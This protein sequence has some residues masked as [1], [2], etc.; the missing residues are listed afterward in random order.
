[1]RIKVGID[2]CPAMDHIRTL[3]RAEGYTGTGGMV[4]FAKL[5]FGA[6]LTLDR[7]GYINR[8]IIDNDNPNSVILGLLI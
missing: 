7:L 1:M 2:G 8:I 3:A 6:T 4:E 5:Q